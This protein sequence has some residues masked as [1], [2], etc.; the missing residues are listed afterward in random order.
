MSTPHVS[1]VVALLLETDSNLTTD[2][3]KTAL[4]DTASSVNKCYGCTR[5]WG[6]Y[7]FRQTEVACTQKITGAGVVDAYEA[8]ST[9]K[10]T[11]EKI[12]K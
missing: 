6:S 5:W 11:T 3:I 8:Y 12:S 1:G 10:T 2:E 4:Y 9:V 7:C